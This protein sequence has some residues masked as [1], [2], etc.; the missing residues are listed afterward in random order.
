M[1]FSIHL[2]ILVLL[3]CAL[4][5]AQEVAPPA[6]PAADSSYRIIPKLGRELGSVVTIAGVVVEGPTK[7]Y[8]GGPNLRVQ[9]IGE[10][11]SQ[12]D[13]QIP[14]SQY[15]PHMDLPKFEMGKTYELEGFET[16]SFVGVSAAAY[17]RAKVML[18]TDEFHFSPSFRY[19]RVRAIPP[20]DWRPAD[21]IGQRCVLSGQAINLTEGAALQHAD[22]EI[23][24]QAGRPWEPW[25]I[26]KEAEAMGVVQ[27][28]AVERS[29]VMTT[30]FARLTRLADQVGRGVSLRGTAWSRN[31][32]WWF[33]YRGQDLYVDDMTNMPGW[34]I[35]LHGVQIEISGT[36]EEAD[37]PNLD[38]ITLKSPQDLKRYGIVRRPTWRRIDGLLF[39]ERSHADAD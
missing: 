19:Y 9:R 38:Q 5:S 13:V 27:R 37:L 25:Q 18:Q 36:L 12:A 3:A 11:V 8:E 33:D 35:D 17:E 7:G 1:S 22:G 23:L 2:I 28:G 10:R 21:L 14:L 15:F 30:E 26:G 4:A 29:F 24:V 16:G 31:G 32:V 6:P 20:I 39:P 34:S